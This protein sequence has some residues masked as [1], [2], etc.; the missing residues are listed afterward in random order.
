MQRKPSDT[1]REFIEQH[2]PMRGFDPKLMVARAWL[3]TVWYGKPHLGYT[4]DYGNIDACWA[5]T[6][7][8]L[9]KVW[10]EALEAARINDGLKDRR[11]AWEVIYDVFKARFA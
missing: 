1:A 10:V 7:D 5:A 6:D 9:R 8:E 2:H 4:K 11:E 3:H